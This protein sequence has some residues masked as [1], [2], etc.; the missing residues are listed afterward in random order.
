MHLCIYEFVHF[1]ICA[2]VQTRTREKLPGMG[3]CD[4]DAEETVVCSEQEVITS[5]YIIIIIFLVIIIII[6][7]IMNVIMKVVISI[8]MTAGVSSGK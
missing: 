4:G 8:S 5:F 1:C 6:R 3:T 7:I 2:F